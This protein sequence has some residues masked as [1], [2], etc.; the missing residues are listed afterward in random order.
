MNILENLLCDRFPFHKLTYIFLDTAVWVSLYII[1]YVNSITQFYV[2]KAESI[3]SAQ[4]NAS[5]VR[6][7]SGT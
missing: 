5:L 3:F 4:L 2:G 7:T 1:A 6:T